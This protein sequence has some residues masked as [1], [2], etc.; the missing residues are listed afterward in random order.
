MNTASTCPDCGAPIKAGASLCSACLLSAGAVTLPMQP[1]STG[2]TALPCE[3]GGYRLLKKLGAGG[4]GVVYE[5]EQVSSGRRLALK[6]LNQ[7]LD[8]EEQRQ[9]FLREGRLAATIEH[10]NSVYVFG[11]EEIDDVPVIAMELAT[12]GTLRDVLKRRGPLPARD[13]VDAMLG[14][15]DG[16]E[17]AHSRG[18]LHR[19]MKPSNCFL[20]SDGKTLVGDYGLSISQTNNVPDGDQLTRSGMIMGTPAFSPPEQLRGQPLDQRAD[21]YSTGGTLYYLLTGKAP[22][23]RTTPVETVAAVLE[24]SIPNVTTLR[25][26]V[27]RDLAEVVSR[28]L[29][30]RPADRFNSYGELRRALLPFSSTAP[31]PAPLGKRVLAGF[32]DGQLIFA[33]YYL[34]ISF[35]PQLS[36]F[37]IGAAQSAQSSWM[38]PVISLIASVLYYAL[39]EARWG[40]TPGKRLCGLCVISQDGARP[41]WKQAVMRAF[42]FLGMPL[43]AMLAML[44]LLGWMGTP[45][46]HDS[47]WRNLTVVAG[48]L[49]ASHSW[50]LLFIPSFRRRDHAGWHDLLTGIRVVQRRQD[51]ERARIAATPTGSVFSGQN[52]G[53]F[54]PGAVIAEDARW[55][56]DPVLRRAVL[57]QKRKDLAPSS[58]RRD[59]ARPGRLRWLQG[60]PDEQDVI[61]DVWQAPAGRSLP[62]LVVESRPE[63]SQV[64]LWLGDLAIEL[65]HAQKDGTL[66]PQVSMSHVWITTDGRALLLDE[67]WPNVNAGTAT[68]D[69]AD[70][71]AVQRFLGEVAELSPRSSRPLH[72]DTLLHGLHH[73]SFERLSHVSGNL[74]HLR[75]K[76]SVVN[77]WSRI[78]SV[79]GPTF[80]MVVFIIIGARLADRAQNLTWTTSHPNLPPLPRVLKL[81][82]HHHSQSASSEITRQIRLHISGHYQSL[83]VNGELRPPPQP[84]GLTSRDGKDLR[85][86]FGTQPVPTDSALA[87][88]DAR[89][90]EELAHFDTSIFSELNL[91]KALPVIALIF[92]AL[93]ALVQ[94]FSIIVSGSPLLMNLI[95]VAAVTDYQRPAG[96][97]RMIW[98]WCIG[99]SPLWLVGAVLGG[100]GL[101]GVRVMPHLPEICQVWM[102]VYLLLVLGAL[103]IPRRSLLDRI[104]GTTLVSR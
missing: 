5:A 38:L 72:A 99:W 43:L 76:S 73:G 21:I 60:V 50:V 79:L 3:F 91:K 27:P 7:S 8:N 30:Q 58:A 41:R 63:W 33:C 53:P 103:L 62:D 28:C 80:V 25:P 59:C 55:G 17:A 66:P 92:F 98:R 89:V 1:V 16:L 32:I 9:R 26:E 102:P 39:Q 64:R 90:A 46:V 47:V 78:A 44:I 31:E 77:H 75:Q 37:S 83:W 51:V 18:V 34:L 100:C 45:T 68:F 19:D 96:R 101:A 67:A 22:V 85:D 81:H 24:G 4:M 56:Y 48:T 11:T 23:E 71:R 49:V 93:S 52:W 54:Q 12:G 82:R 20:T 61:W 40:A 14:I 104:A 88:V 57:L 97:L 74:E 42:I 35:V 36:P 2:I 13:A 69:T 10:P 15:I 70:M 65:D 84:N 95:G 94:L 29:A 87:A 6:V 86:I